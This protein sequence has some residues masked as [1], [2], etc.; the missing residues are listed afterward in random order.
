LLFVSD[1][2]STRTA[3]PV[4]STSV[5]SHVPRVI[6]WRVSPMRELLKHGAS[7]QARNRGRAG[8]YA[9]C[10]AVAELARLA[11]PPFTPRYVTATC[12]VTSRVS[13]LSDYSVYTRGR[14]QW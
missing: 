4:S 1:V 8:C 7:S 14:R 10:A 9:K 13:T 6:L 2:F 12:S 5:N 3:L 11:S